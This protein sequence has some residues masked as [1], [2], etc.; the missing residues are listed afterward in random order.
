MD[1]KFLKSFLNI[2]NIH[3]AILVLIFLFSKLYFYI[4]K[5]TNNYFNNFSAYIFKLPIVIVLISF[6]V[7]VVIIKKIEQ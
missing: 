7:N 2:F 1:K 5:L 4:D 6:I 3:I